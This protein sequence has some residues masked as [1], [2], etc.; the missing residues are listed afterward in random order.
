MG[1]YNGAGIHGTDEVSSLG[2]AASH[3]CIRMAIPDVIALYDQVPARHADLHRQLAE[4]PGAGHP[5]ATDPG[6]ALPRVGPAPQN[7]CPTPAA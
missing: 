3:G 2:T 5:A 1:F 6:G 4:R 7:A